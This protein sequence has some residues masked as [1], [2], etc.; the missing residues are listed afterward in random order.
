MPRQARNWSLGA[1]YHIMMRGNRKSQIFHEPKDY[2]NYLNLLQRSSRNAPFLLHSHC[3]MNNHIHLLLQT[4][5]HTP[6]NIFRPVNTC[7]AMYYNHKYNAVGHLFQGRFKAKLVDT[8]SYLLGVSKYI[9]LNPVEANLVKKPE[10]YPWSSY[11]A[12]Y[13]QKYDPLVHTEKV[14]SF[15]P[16]SPASSYNEFILRKLTYQEQEE[17]ATYLRP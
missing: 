9:H 6:T 17:A 13:Q 7:Y 10:H 4:L 8:T 11:P 15:F 5:K 16:D 3:L 14:L 2:Q 12:F 1:T